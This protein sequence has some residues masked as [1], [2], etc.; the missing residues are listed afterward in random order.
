MSSCHAFREALSASL[1]DELRPLERA[2]LD[3]H[4]ADCVS[5]RSHAA[6]VQRLHR[7]TRVTP[8]DAVPDLTHAILTTHRAST[9]STAA[10][11]ADWRRWA[12][13]VLGLTIAVLSL[14]SLLVGDASTSIHLS[15]ELAAWEVALSASLL[16]AAWQPRRAEG[17]FPLAGVV[18]VI[19]FVTAIADA[20]AGDT[21]VITEA[22]HVL[23]LAAVGILFSLSRSHSS[24]RSAA[25]AAV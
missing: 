24:P 15:R 2:A 9:R 11:T 6:E 19:L 18:V 17:V 3:G 12:L 14:P 16:L 4:L 7:M 20:A 22:H 25:P 10:D 21:R 5:C 23:E 1:D 13:A 8:A